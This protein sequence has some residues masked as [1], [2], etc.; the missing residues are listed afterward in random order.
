MKT[1]M[2]AAVLLTAASTVPALALDITKSVTVSTAPATVWQA[3]GP[4]CAIGDWHPA[5]ASCTLSAKGNKKVRTLELKG[6]G[7]IVEEQ[8]FRDNK[9]MKYRYTILKSP[10]PVSHYTSTISVA[11]AGTGATVIWTGHFM[12]KGATNAKA[13]DVI[14][15]IYDAGLKSIGDKFGAAGK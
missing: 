14:G 3:I 1:M 9:H 7:T 15:G 6:G 2:A 10:L 12:A 11:P 5:I 4:F 8:L 13:E